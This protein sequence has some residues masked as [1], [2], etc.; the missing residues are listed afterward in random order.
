MKEIFGSHVPGDTP[1]FVLGLDDDERRH[2][3]DWRL[4]IEAGRVRVVNVDEPHR[5]LLSLL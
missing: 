4:Q 1:D 2:D 5:H 3:V